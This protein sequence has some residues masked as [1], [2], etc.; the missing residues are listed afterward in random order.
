MPRIDRWAAY[1]YRE[2]GIPVTEGYGPPW[3]DVQIR[4]SSRCQMYYHRLMGGS[5]TCP[6]TVDNSAIVR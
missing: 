6:Q 3:F 2:N 1:G 4:C 5:A